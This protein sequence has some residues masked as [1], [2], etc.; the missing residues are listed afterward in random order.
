MNPRESVD[1]MPSYYSP[2]YELIWLAE[3]NCVVP[4]QRYGPLAI[5]RDVCRVFELK[6]YQ[7]YDYLRVQEIS[8]PRQI[9][10]YVSKKLT[11]LTDTK[12][13]GSF[14]RNRTALYFG[15]GVVNNM[16]HTK[17]ERF[18]SYWN[19]YVEESKIYKLN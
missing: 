15:V 3:K 6:E 11:G 1:R 14:R 17:D 8:I 12:L 4:G 2:H 13:A 5:I 7:I 9:A 19:R 10:M 18:M 16:L